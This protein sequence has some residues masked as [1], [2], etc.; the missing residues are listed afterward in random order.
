MKNMDLLK[1]GT[2]QPTSKVKQLGSCDI[3][4]IDLGTTNSAVSVFT[5][6]TVPTLLPIGKN[7]SPTVPSCVRWDGHDEGGEPIFTVGAAAYAERYKPNVIYSIKRMMGSGETVSF[8]S[9]DKGKS[10]EMTPAA[11]SGIILRHIKDKVAEFYAPITKCIITVPAYFNQ[12]QMED[13]IKAAELAGL[14]CLQVLKEP[15]SASFIYSQLGYAQ[16]GSVLIYDLGGGTFD[17]THMTFL[18]K[19]AVPK[20]MASS[21]KRQYGITLDNAGGDVTDQYYSRV[22][23]TYGDMKLGGDDIDKMFGDRAIKEQKVELSES[24][25]EQVYLRCEAFKKRGIAG[26]DIVVEDKVIHLDV[27]MLNDCVDKI[28]DRTMKIIQDIDVSEVTSIVLVGG[29]TKS[30]RLRQ[31]L[32]SAFPKLEISAVLDPD[33]TVA[34]GAGAVAK[35]VANRKDLEYSD[36]LPLPI[37][38]LVNESSIDVCLQKNTSMPYSTNR[39]YYTLHDNQDRISVHVFQGLST[40]PE[41]CTYLGRITVD[42]IPPKPAGD[43][44]VMLSFILTGQGRLKV[45]S[46]VEGVD[47]EEELVVDNIF[48]VAQGANGEGI[49]GGATTDFVPADDFETMVYDAVEDSKAEAQELLLK[50][51]SLAEDSAE[52]FELE[53]SIFSKFFG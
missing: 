4:G 25:R 29:S 34:L 13:T 12:R 39:T 32:Q 27:N 24:G 28:F 37:G 43:V 16:S 9:P 8:C 19:D 52:R 33:A 48:T 53:N 5:A 46:R 36:V 10:L 44:C 2:E 22:I 23:G 38:V 6:G 47:R 21:L 15:T 45:V 51:R 17:A 41:K 49:A 50:R 7:G 31:D 14:E 1:E 42:G 3:I 26:E 20:K 11:V 35:A 30:P 18:R 40:K